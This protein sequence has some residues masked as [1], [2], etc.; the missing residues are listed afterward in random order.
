M[1][2]NE[3]NYQRA[4]SLIK[5]D[6]T[7]KA[8]PKKG[9]KMM[10]EL[11][12]AGYEPACLNLAHECWYTGKYADAC[13]YF[14]KAKL[15]KNEQAFE[16]VCSLYRGITKKQRKDPDY[17]ASVF[18]K[19]K[20]YEEL[21]TGDGRYYYALLLHVAQPENEEGYK[22]QLYYAALGNSDYM[23]DEAYEFIGRERGVLADKS[24]MDIWM[25][26]SSMAK[27]A[28]FIPCERSED[29]AWF[30]AE[31]A[32]EDKET[33]KFL[34]TAQ[35]KALLHAKPKAILEYQQIYRAAYN[36]GTIKFGFKYDNPNYSTV[37]TGTATLNVNKY[38][39]N[40][41]ATFKTKQSQEQLWK[42]YN[43]VTTTTTY[44]DA[45]VRTNAYGSATVIERC[46]EMT[47]K[48]A[49]NGAVWEAKDAEAKQRNWETR[50]IT[51]NMQDYDMT[52]KFIELV[53]VPFYFFTVT[54]TGK[55]T[56]TARVNGYSGE[57][58]FFVDNP[59]GQFT[60]ED[61]VAQGGG[62]NETTRDR[63]KKQSAKNKAKAKRIAG[64]ILK[65][66]LMIVGGVLAGVG[67]LFT[68]LALTSDAPGSVIVGI[69]PLALGIFLF[70]KG[71]N[72]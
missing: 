23:P 53:F 4:Q 7:V 15:T 16:Y 10:G 42:V 40:S 5:G 18:A 56:V 57:I 26:V 34:N 29:D 66:I 64:G 61:N 41:C 45:R 19:A 24:E 13:V 12:D 31:Q 28:K 49:R 33:N 3:Q 35:R 25:K 70:F 47:R 6:S 60:E 68:I 54:T 9:W 17:L 59:F 22:Q 51:I 21:Y 39:T 63:N 11:A 38:W 55:K 2:T 48:D 67:A 37:S 52:N 69:I 71:K 1:A 58:D 62:A 50:Y 20:K 46:G 65:K 8:N 44:K 36:I 72:M 27:Y 32:L 43:K 30:I 14:E